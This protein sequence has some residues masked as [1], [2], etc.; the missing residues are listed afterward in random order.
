MLTKG[1]PTVGPYSKPST[2]EEEE[3]TEARAAVQDLA[4]FDREPE[5]P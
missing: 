4:R 2:E 3:A 1:K 5:S